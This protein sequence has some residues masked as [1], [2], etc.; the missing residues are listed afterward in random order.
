MHYEWN[1]IKRGAKCKKKRGKQ[2]KK[3]LKKHKNV[4]AVANVKITYVRHAVKLKALAICKKQ[5]KS[6]DHILWALTEFCGQ[7]ADM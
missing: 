6:E 3:I 7:N 5:K 2:I 1:S 4:C